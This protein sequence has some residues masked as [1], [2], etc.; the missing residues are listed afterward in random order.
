MD[1]IHADGLD[2][3]E[4][5]MRQTPLH[6]PLHRAIH[7]FPACLKHLGGLAPTQPPRPPRQESHHGAG[8]G[9]LAFAPGNVLH[10]HTMLA[11]LHAPGSIEKAGWNSPERHKLPAPLRQ[12]IVARRWTT[13]PGAA[14]ADPAM[15]L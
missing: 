15:R 14:P 7:R 3:L 5:A 1:L 13:T 2:S 10:H 11:T 12:T 9:A 8:D 4:L 6:K